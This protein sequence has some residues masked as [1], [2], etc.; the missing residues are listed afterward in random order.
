[1]KG[2]AVPCVTCEV[3]VGQTTFAASKAP[4]GSLRSVLDLS[5]GTLTLTAAGTVAPPAAGASHLTV[6]ERKSLVTSLRAAF[7]RP[8]PH[9][10][11]ARSVPEQA[12]YKN[13]SDEK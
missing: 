4:L 5:E 8:F 12:R 7:A 11:D 10:A 6:R 13:V 9:G 2:T 1:M 3:P